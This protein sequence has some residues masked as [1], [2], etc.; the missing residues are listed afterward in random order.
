MTSHSQNIETL[1]QVFLGRKPE[2]S[3]L[4]NNADRSLSEIA[5]QIAGSG[6]FRKRFAH[7]PKKREAPHLTSFAQERLIYIHIPKCGGTTLHHLLKKWYGKEQFH[8]ERH[9]HLYDYKAVDLAHHQVFSGHFDYYSTKLIPGGLHRISFLR[10]PF[11]RLVSLYNFHRAHTPKV[12]EE[13]D[14][15]LARWANAM[16]I[17]EYFANEQVRAHPAVDNTMARHF[18]N[19][20]QV[21]HLWNGAQ[22]PNS[23]NTEL[24][25][26]QALENI[27]QFTYIGFLEEYDSS[28]RHL[29]A[30]LGAP[31]DTEIERKQS[32]DTLMENDPGMRKIER[33]T[34]S[35]TTLESM[36]ELVQHD[37]TVYNAAKAQFAPSS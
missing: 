21:Q 35:S 18:S 32:L 24:M 28:V 22:N 15:V 5:Q 16:D 13:Q 7:K 36:K 27:R 26:K 20:P 3:A 8:P 17:D 30:L 4:A 11:D 29:A 14:L 19:V 37:I 23:Q 10:D 9:N 33:Q 34:P 12:I 25:C 31:T 6:E 2:A 1:Y